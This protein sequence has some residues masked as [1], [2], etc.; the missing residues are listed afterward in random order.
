MAKI[1]SQYTGGTIKEF[2]DVLWPVISKARAQGATVQEVFEIMKESCPTMPVVEFSTFSTA[3]HTVANDK[4]ATVEKVQDG[5][6]NAPVAVATP[7]S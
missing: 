1:K 6:Q 5:T 7:T 3:Y 2:I 4:E